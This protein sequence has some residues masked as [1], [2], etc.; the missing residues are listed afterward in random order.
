[1]CIYVC[2][3]YMSHILTETWTL[4]RFLLYSM[5]VPVTSVIKMWLSCLPWLAGFTSQDNTEDITQPY[6]WQLIPISLLYGDT[7]KG[8]A[9]T[10]NV[11]KMVFEQW[12]GKYSLECKQGLIGDKS[13]EP[14][15]PPTFQGKFAIQ[16]YILNNA[17]ILKHSCGVTSP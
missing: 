2:L 6:I 13:L 5:L 14:Y 15:T 1:M 7:E 3:L 8:E 17:I 4:D 11:N 10:V 9:F 12:R 16:F